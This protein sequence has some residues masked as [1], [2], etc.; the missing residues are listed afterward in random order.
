M[1]KLAVIFPDI[2]KEEE[3]TRKNNFILEYFG[4]DF[5]FTY[6]VQ[7][8]ATKNILKEYLA[9]GS[10]IVDFS[11]DAINSDILLFYKSEITKNYHPEYSNF[12]SGQGNRDVYTLEI[13]SRIRRC[14]TKLPESDLPHA[15]THAFNKLGPKTPDG[16]F[17]YF[18]YGYLFKYPGLG[19]INPFGFRVPDNYADLAIRPKKHKLILFF[20]GSAMWSMY[21]YINEMF[22]AV[23]EKMLNEYCKHKKIDLQ[24]SILNFGMHGHIVLNE[25]ITYLLFCQKLNPD[26]V[27]AHDGW[28]DLIYGMLSDKFLL[29]EHQLAYQYNLEGWSQIL[30]KTS[31]L[32]ATQSNKDFQP[33]N[34]PNNVVS[35]YLDRKNQFRQLVEQ[36][37]AKFIWALQPSIYSKKSHSSE[38][39]EYLQHE[40]QYTNS[41]REPYKRM[42]FIYETYI[43]RAAKELTVPF[44]NLHAYFQ[45]FGDEQTLFGDIIHTVPLGDY[46]IAQYYFEYFQKI[47][48]Q[49]KL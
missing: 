35:A 6:Y 8:K 13:D 40:L 24:F 22:P 45:N 3:I 43:K 23:L 38:E 29:N 37:G 4:K 16:E 15:Y 14:D 39:K 30:H 1:K 18:P 31:D 32:K 21:S 7:D 9:T 5:S 12:S 2:I 25:M 26:Y 17:Y 41:F 20:G 44:L 19:P 34:L 33:I 10:S 42:S 46:K 49:E 47:I 27:V 11:N 36:N 48:E 28:N